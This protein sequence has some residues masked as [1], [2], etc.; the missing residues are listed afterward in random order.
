MAKWTA[1][2]QK[3]VDDSIVPVLTDWLCFVYRYRLNSRGGTSTPDPVKF[4][5]FIFELSNKKPE[6][7]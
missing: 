1:N 4:V 3:L 5:R 6:C 7:I 2:D